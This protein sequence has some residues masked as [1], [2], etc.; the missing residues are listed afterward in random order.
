M[1]DFIDEYLASEKELVAD[2]N[3]PNHITSEAFRA[4]S[5]HLKMLKGFYHDRSIRLED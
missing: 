3:K 1:F 2:C 4:K 5:H